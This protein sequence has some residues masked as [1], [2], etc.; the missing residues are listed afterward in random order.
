MD[1]A[2][3]GYKFLPAMFVAGVFAGT[4]LVYSCLGDRLRLR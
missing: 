1:G 3:A 2:A 4:L